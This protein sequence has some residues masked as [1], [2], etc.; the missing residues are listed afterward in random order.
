MDLSIQGDDKGKLHKLESDITLSIY[1]YR[2]KNIRILCFVSIRMQIESRIL[3]EDFV[4]R[5]FCI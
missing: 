5:T 1:E 2:G 3:S 4:Q